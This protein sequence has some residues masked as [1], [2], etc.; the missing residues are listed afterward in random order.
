MKY[1]F[2]KIALLSLSVYAVLCINGVLQA[3]KDI[4]GVLAI[5]VPVFVLIQVEL[6]DT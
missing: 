4:W 6:G 3:P 2:T 5:C 1:L